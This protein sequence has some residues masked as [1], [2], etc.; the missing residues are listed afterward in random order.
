M[1]NEF[2]RVDCVDGP[3]A[4]VDAVNADGVTLHEARRTRDGWTAMTL[5]GNRQAL[6]SL[7][8]D[9]WQFTPDQ[10]EVFPHSPYDCNPTDAT[11]S[12]EDVLA[13][14]DREPPCPGC[15]CVAGQGLT[16]GCTHPEGCGYWVACRAEAMDRAQG[17]TS[18]YD[19]PPDHIIR[20]VN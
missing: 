18:H 17:M 8:I 9:Y 12:L 6:T 15:G 13:A 16:P 20:S 4:I 11:T 5:E 1:V 19:G 3:T 10:V 2:W 14:E 7:V